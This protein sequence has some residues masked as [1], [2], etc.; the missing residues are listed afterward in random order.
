MKI[1]EYNYVEL[2]KRVNGNKTGSLS[3]TWRKF[4]SINHKRMCGTLYNYNIVYIIYVYYIMVYMVQR[5][6][7][8]SHFKML[9]LL[10]LRLNFQKAQV[11]YTIF[12]NTYIPTCFYTYVLSMNVL[13]QCHWNVFHVHLYT[14]WKGWY[15]YRYILICV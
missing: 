4:T 3:G 10:H 6:T 1:I 11:C 14:F 8:I 7:R 2:N 9:N 15:M 12:P 13:N 5:E